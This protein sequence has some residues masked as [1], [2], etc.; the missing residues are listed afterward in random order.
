MD[1]VSYQFQTNRIHT[2]VLRFLLRGEKTST[3]VVEIEF[4][5]ELENELVLVDTTRQR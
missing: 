2:V 3:K 5:I 1:C 4:D